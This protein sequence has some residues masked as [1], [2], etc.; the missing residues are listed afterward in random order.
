[1]KS[2]VLTFPLTLEAFAV[3]QERR[4]G[5]EFPE[6][7]REIIAG[8]IPLANLAYQAGRKGETETLRNIITAIQDQAG[9]SGDD[10]QVVR[11]AMVVKWWLDYA[12]QRGRAEA[13]GGYYDSAN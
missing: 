12:W 9:D 3:H 5:V 1:M 7:V 10:P 6:E 2:T 13:K 4:S 11:L 8:F